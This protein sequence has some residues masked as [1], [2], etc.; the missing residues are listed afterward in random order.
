MRITKTMISSLAATT[1][2]SAALSS[3]A[4]AASPKWR[5]VEGGYTN[6]EIGR[7]DFDG[8]NVGGKYLFN[9]NFFVSGEYDMLD[10]SGTDLDLLTLGGGYRLPIN[11]FTDA[12]FGVNYERVELENYD[13]SGYSVDAG[14][15]SML[16]E[17]VELL[18]EIGYYDVDDGDVTVKIGANYYFT[19]QWAIG[20][21]YKKIDDL[22]IT[23]ITARYTF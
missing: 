2:L 8:L 12:Y 6:A 21:N 14:V 16:T 22:D 7:A 10:E 9:N 5:F 18:G 19:P 11:S 4:L 20:A 17:Q 23:Q 15:R 1:L 13:D 3:S